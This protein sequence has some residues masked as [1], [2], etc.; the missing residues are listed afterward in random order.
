MQT[1]KISYYQEKDKEAYTKR[2]E[3]ILIKTRKEYYDRNN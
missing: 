1:D 3:Q 2:N